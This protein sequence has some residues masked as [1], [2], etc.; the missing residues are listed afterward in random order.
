MKVGTPTAA[1]STPT[2]S[3]SGATRVRAT[4]SAATTKAPPPSALAGSRTGA[5]RTPSQPERVRNDEPDEADRARRRDR[6]AGRERGREQ[7]AAAAPADRH[8]ER[9]GPGVAARQPVELARARPDDDQRHGERRPD[10]L[11]A[12]RAVQIAEQ[13]EDHAAQLPLVGQGQDQGDEGR[14]AG[15]DHHA[16]EQEGRRCVGLRREGAAPPGGARAG[17]RAAPTRS[18]A[19]MP[20]PSATPHSE[21]A[22]RSRRR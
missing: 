8:A 17:R 19:P 9:R 11:P 3:C 5:A 12:R 18:V 21:S 4:A 6:R 1:A 2:G 13:P 7:D 15:A 10:D 16:D 14:A 22:R 20:A